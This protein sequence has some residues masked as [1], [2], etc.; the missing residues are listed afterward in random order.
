M[1]KKEV[2]IHS[3]ER[4]E[5]D[6]SPTAT[7]I[8][9][10]LNAF[11]VDRISPFG[12]G[13]HYSLGG[14]PEDPHATLEHY[15]ARGMIRYS[16]PDISIVF[17]GAEAPKL[18]GEG[19]IFIAQSDEQLRSIA[20]AADGHVRLETTNSQEQGSDQVAVYERMARLARKRNAPQEALLKQWNELAE[21]AKPEQQEESKSVEL[22]GRAAKDPVSGRTKRNQ[23]YARF[24]LEAGADDEFVTH[25]VIVFG[26]RANH[27]LEF[28]HKDGLYTIRGEKSSYEKDGQIHQNI[29]LKTFA[30]GDKR[31]AREATPRS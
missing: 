20:I 8:G 11:P 2:Q 19:V 22:Y 3:L 6:M 26:P 21:K 28:V 5:R 14:T 23:L 17:R 16:T 10:R 18:T 7:D 30:L 12:E 4:S 13:Q 31:S 25:P 24:P 29:K 27:V 1:S 15:P 9:A